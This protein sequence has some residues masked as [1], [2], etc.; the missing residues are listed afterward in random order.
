MEGPDGGVAV[1][2][3][4]QAGVLRDFDVVGVGVVFDFV[5]GSRLVGEGATVAGSGSVGVKVGDEDVSAGRAD[6]HQLAVGRAD[7]RQMS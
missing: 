6:A 2:D 4:G 1:G 3:E 5:H 7:V